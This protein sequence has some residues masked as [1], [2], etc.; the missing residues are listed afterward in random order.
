LCSLFNEK[1]SFLDFKDQSLNDMRDLILELVF[2]KPTI[3][4]ED[5]N[6]ELINKGFAIQLSK[7]MQSN[8]PARL[9]INKHKIEISR[10]REILKELL[11]LI[12]LKLV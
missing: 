2:N 10:V 4:F 3:N 7:I 5:L 11:D 12:Y 6:S 9:N 8:I 1:L